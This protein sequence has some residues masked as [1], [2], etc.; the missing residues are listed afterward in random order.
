MIKS[1]VKIYCEEKAYNNFKKIIDR[2]KDNQP[3]RIQVV[4]E[5]DKHYIIT[6]NNIDWDYRLKRTSWG[7]DIQEL[8]YFLGSKTTK[9]YGYK[10]ISANENIEHLDNWTNY[11]HR[12]FKV[13]EKYHLVIKFIEPQEEITDIEI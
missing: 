13:F 8:M 7:K 1:V 3:N 11:N 2:Y 5:G 12:G 6:W 10:M 9:G 4:N